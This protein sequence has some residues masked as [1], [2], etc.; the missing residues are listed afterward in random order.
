MKKLTVIGRGIVGCLAVA[1]FTKHTDWVIDWVYDPAL[2]PNPVGE[3]TTLSIPS[4]LRDTVLFDWEDMYK[5]QGTPKTGIMKR[6]WSLQKDFF[7]PFMLGQVGMHMN[8]VELQRIMFEKL[9][10]HPRVSTSEQNV[11]RLDTFD[12]DFI[13]VCNGTPSF[14]NDTYDIRA[15]IP[16]H[17]C[18]VSQCE[19][20]YPR[21]HYSLTNAAKHGWYFGIPLQNRC[22]IGY[23]FSEGFSSLDEVENDAN[24]I[25]N[26]LDLTKTTQRLITFKNYS[27][28]NNFDHHIVYNGNASFFLEP[29]EATSTSLSCQIL[30][31]AHAIWTG[32]VLPNDAEHLYQ[33]EIDNIEA[34]ICLHYMAGSV[35]NTKFW[36]FAK[37][38]A[39][40]KIK[41]KMMDESYRKFIY[42]A[43]FPSQTDSLYEQQVM[44]GWRKFSYKMN[45]EGLGIR[46]RIEEML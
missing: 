31:A 46:E 35:Y 24:N 41:I 44:G 9:S 26:E 25:L 34:M 16:V 14:H 43:L 17:A 18:L 10:K 7:H 37:E 5:I 1:Y 45:I 27:K 20:E 39:T 11:S 8:A 2:Q 23:L 42:N 33:R 12:T 21:I 3:G 30:T 28:R 36:K 32:K 22:S 38:L 6:N 40:E 15:Y 19:W 13:M 4:L 29:L